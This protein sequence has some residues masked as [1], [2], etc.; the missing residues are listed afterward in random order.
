MTTMCSHGRSSRR[1]F[2][3]QACATVGAAIVAA[4]FVSITPGTSAFAAGETIATIDPEARIGNLSIRLDASGNPVIVYHDVTNDV[5]KLVHCDDPIC[6]A[7]DDVPVVLDADGSTGVDP[8][9]QLDAAGFPVISYADTIVSTAARRGLRVLRC[10]DPGCT[11]GDDVPVVVD[12]AAGGRFTGLSSSLQLDAAGN[13]VISYVDPGGSNVYVIHCNDPACTDGDDAPSSIDGSSVSFP[14]TTSLQLDAA[15]NPVVAY[16]SALDLRIVHCNDPACAGG[17][18]LPTVLD[19]TG[20]DPSLQL[21]A[22]GNPVISY[23]GPLGRVLLRCGDPRCVDGSNN[24]TTL[25]TS[26]DG[27]AALQ[28]DATGNPVV[29]VGSRLLGAE[30]AL[31]VIHCNDP[32]C[33]GGDET[34]TPIGPTTAGIASRVSLVLDAG[35]RPVIGLSR[36]FAAGLAVIR[37]DDPACVEGDADRD[38][39]PDSTDNCSDVTNPDQADSDGDRVG[40][41]CEPAPPVA[42]SVPVTTPPVGTLPATGSPYDRIGA[43]ALT[44]CLAGWLL[45]ALARRSC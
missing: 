21:D 8:S 45:A 17:D 19:P 41:A 11:G 42:P 4:V 24:T 43:S 34:V 32:A 36:V 35:D 40:D 27:S 39:V 31:E 18:D 6:G 38:G 26:L 37:C 33:A 2:V 3:R 22:A 44:L 20:R 23:S 16:D 30:P 1:A 28:L 15:G 9:L 25:L 5:M 12:P 29:V 13:P 10:N 7:G 14:A